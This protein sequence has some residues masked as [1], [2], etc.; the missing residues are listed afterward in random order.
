MIELYH[1]TNK[2]KG[3]ITHQCQNYL[4][5]LHWSLPLQF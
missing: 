5:S 4:N 3:E 2:I 1:K